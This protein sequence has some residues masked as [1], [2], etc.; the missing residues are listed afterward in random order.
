[1]VPV[2]GAS[3][4]A[5]IFLSIGIK[6]YSQKRGNHDTPKSGGYHWVEVPQPAKGPLETKFRW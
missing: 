3:S 1:M 5:L 2:R 6:N 4:F